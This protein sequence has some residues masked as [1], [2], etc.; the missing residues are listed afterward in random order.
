MNKNIFKVALGVAL[1]TT[2]SLTSCDKEPDESDLYTFTGQTIQDFLEENDSVFSLFNVIMSR[3]GY[4]RMMDAYG[5]YTCYAPVNEGVRKYVDSLYNDPKAKV[6]HNGMTENSV[7]GLTDEQCK[8]IAMFHLSNIENTYIEVLSNT[9][10]AE[11]MTMLNTP[12]TSTLGEDGIVRLGEVAA[13]I[14]VTSYDH[15]ME[16]GYVHVITGVI[17]R[18]TTHVSE[19]MADFPQYKIFFEALEKC[20]LLD[21]LANDRKRE[22]DGSEK[23]YSLS[24]ISGRPGSG[25]A[26]GQYYVPAECKI[27]YTI[28]AEDSTAF[29][30]AGIHS[31]EDLKAKCAEWYGN[32]AE[33]YDYLSANG[34]Q[35]STGDDYTN[36]WN[37]VNMF[38]R[39]HIV[40]QG[41]A[42]G[43]LVYER[44]ANR[45]N[46]NWN[47]AFGGEPY[48]YYETLL[49][50]TL[51]KIWQ[52][53][54][55]NTGTA[56]NIWINRWRRNNTLTD[57][58]GTYG[59]DATHDIIQDGCL[60][61]RSSST[62]AHTNITAYNGYIHAINKPLV[63]DAN[64]PNGVLH[65]RLRIDMGDI[66][67]ELTNNRI[68]YASGAEIGAM[69]LSSNDGTMVRLPLDYFDNLVSYNNKTK[70]AW[71]VTGAWRAWQ[72]DQLSGWDENDFAFRLPPVPAGTYEVRIIYPPMANSGLQQYYLGTS[73][74]PS[75]MI[76][77]GIPI[78]ARYPNSGNEEDRLS[79]GYM[80]STEFDDFGV[81]SDL[82]MRNH[83]YMRAPASFARGTQNTIPARISSPQDLVDNISASCR[84]EEG[85]G[86]SMMRKILG[87]YQFEPGKEYWIRLKNLLQGYDQLGF[88]I[89]FIEL[90]PIDIVNSQDFTE[91]WY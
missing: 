66:L 73:T 4:D 55:Q 29:A 70:L 39:Y 48:D 16:N 30:Q 15:E 33:W 54:Y 69:N 56:S 90:V 75:S 86:T 42:Y 31:F 71:Y 60:I 52:P 83:G 78:D 17:P 34:I 59:S 58:I 82:V 76:P 14:Q 47:Y 6:E 57:E 45:S 7:A 74:D 10:G 87:T 32:A 68:R 12:F 21:T 20:G 26:S 38:L 67:H 36:Q 51:M 49:P 77:M 25:M 5:T 79:T 13:D 61:R 11:I 24:N 9:G 91:D 22:A 40:K 19:V 41:M 37:V 89:D 23:K 53:L 8:E 18:N 65:E 27:A 84:Y 63:Y 85:Y 72:S 3:S 44:D 28:F 50:H 81:A 80:L 43:K 1:G 35:P 46:E 62:V 2:L 88:S 64:V